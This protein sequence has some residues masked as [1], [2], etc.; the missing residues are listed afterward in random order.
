[1]LATTAFALLLG[2]LVRAVLNAGPTRRAAI[3][4]IEDSARAYGAEIEVADLHWG[5]LPPE[6]RLRGVRLETGSIRAE[7][8]R[9]QVSLARV[10]LTR[11]TIELGTVAASGVHVALDGLPPGEGGSEQ[12]LTLRVRHLELDD[13]SFEGINLPGRT[14]LAFDD[15][16]AAWTDDGL[17]A[18]GY[19]E[20]PR[21]RFQIGR[22]PAV[23][24]AVRARY[25]LAAEA[26]DLAT[27]QL[28]GDG[29]SLAGRGRVASGRATATVS[30]QLDVG[31]LDSFI[32]GGGLLGGRAAFDL[33]LDSAAEFPLA[34]HVQAP[35][36][37]V[38]SY[39]FED[40]EG[41]LELGRDRSLRGT[42]SRARFLGGSVSG[43]YRLDGL[44]GAYAHQVEVAIS[45][46]SLAGFL[47]T[48]GV[49]P[50]GLGSRLDVAATAA[51]RGRA[52]PAGDGHADVALR[53]SAAALPVA[54]ALGIDLAGDGLLRFSGSDL[55]V[56]D[57]T[58][59][60]Q[61]TLALDGWEPAWS[62]AA[63]PARLD[64]VAGL[65]NALVGSP[66]LPAEI[67]GAGSLE[68]NLSGPFDELILTAHVDARPLL[69]PPIAIDRLVA[70]LSV[71]GEGLRVAGAHFQIGDGSGEVEGRLRWDEDAADDQ[72]QLTTRGSRLPLAAAASWFG[73]ESAVGAGTLSFDGVLEG[74]LALPR[75]SWLVSI[76]ELTL[77]GLDVGNASTLVELAEGRFA[78]RDLTSDR[79]LEAELRWDV[80]AAE[81]TGNLRWPRLSL[82]PLGA[83][84]TGLAGERADVSADFQVPLGGRPTGRLQLVS[85]RARLDAVAGLE[86][87]EVEATIADAL[88]ARAALGRGEDGSLRGSGELTL[89]S[90]QSLLG[91]L[92]PDSGVPLT[93]TGRASFDIEW[94]D[95]PLPRITGVLQ[96]LDLQLAEQ[97]VELVAPARFTLNDAGF[98]AAGLQ[99]RALE[100]TLFV[101][102]AIA[103]DGGLRGNVSGTM[104]ALLL[105]FLMPDWEPAGRATGVVEILGT[106]AT[107]LFEGIAEIGRA[108]FRLPGTR[109]ILSQVQGTVLLSSEE[110][111]LKGVD[112]RLMGGRGRCSGRILDRGGSIMLVLGGTANGVRFE[113]LPAL[114]AR[115][116][117]DWRLSGPV[118][119]LSLSGEL[120]VDRMSLVSRDSASDLLLRWLAAAER[121]SP[122]GGLRLDLQVEAEESISLR[123]PFVRLDGSAVLDVTGTSNRPGLVGQIEILEGGEATFLGTRYEVERGSISFSNPMAVEPFFDLQAST[124]VQEFQ[125]T[126]NLSGT[127]DNF[128]STA[129]STPPLSA[130]EIYSLLGVGYRAE[131]LGTGAVGLGLA[132]SILSNRLTSVLS[133]RAQM[134]LPIDEVRVDPFSADSTGNPTARLSIVKQLTPS[135]TVIL[136]TT[137]SGKR[138][139]IITSRWYLAP[140]L[141]LEASQREDGTLAADI[142]LRRP[143]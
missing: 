39:R 134:V 133:E 83:A 93:G 75:G 103:A 119:D 94:D 137:L 73:L 89:V 110:I 16:R 138:E 116:S 102:W 8:Q 71:S 36:L 78:C 13:V 84:A 85:E 82:L 64:E 20:V 124:W 141:F 108:S 97:P 91:L 127:F 18:R 81:V 120:Q 28:T 43:S 104:D 14:A 17:A 12:S 53:P 21:V 70:D 24:V 1:V 2:L 55:E 31:R 117:G 142:K 62:L 56:G 92:L 47:A 123:S 118:D 72:L 130:P 27:F 122:E 49:E 29:L 80:P 69:L 65:V 129:V 38:E 51:W 131:G 9:L 11:R 10:R 6:L 54:G 42:L 33:A 79:G 74:P 59:R 132:S 5:L 40:A 22:A 37:E 140:G 121:P 87:I 34:A 135:W 126:L 52:F 26:L 86:T 63:D 57:S 115:L 98:A 4:W 99:L 125:V 109:T 111:E 19:A 58:L 128:M 139:Q 25:E 100:D 32:R 67:G 3:R 112:F 30:G 107:P 106:T 45:D 48:I 66:V 60:W 7:V 96:R 44:G 76:E 114:E 105:R 61:G 15:L 143:Y 88:A 95:E 23:E 113:V 101:R 136:Q 35:W 90:A 68:V 41:D 77:A 46:L 50:A